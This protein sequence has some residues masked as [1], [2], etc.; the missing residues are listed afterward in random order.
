MTANRT[1]HTA[2]E[3]SWAGLFCADD[4]PDSL[5]EEDS[6]WQATFLP[7]AKQEDD[8]KQLVAMGYERE[9]VVKALAD[10]GGDILEALNKLALEQ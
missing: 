9:A 2:E 1:L 7:Q 8:T 5:V 10:S 3:E 6:S 4:S